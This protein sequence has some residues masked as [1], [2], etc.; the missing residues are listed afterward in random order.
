MRMIC[1]LKCLV[2]TPDAD[3]VTANQD[4]SLSV[5]TRD[6]KLWGTDDKARRATSGLQ[7]G[8]CL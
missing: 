4:M 1:D 3:A 2:S 8:V 6:G 7:T 5:K